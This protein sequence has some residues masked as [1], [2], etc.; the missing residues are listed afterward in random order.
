MENEVDT[1]LAMKFYEVA[2]NYTKANWLQL[3]HTFVAS[4]ENNG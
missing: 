2:P 1:Y 3:V 4:K